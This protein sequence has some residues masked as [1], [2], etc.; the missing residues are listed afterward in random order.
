[1]SLS[2]VIE[3]ALSDVGY[4][5]SGTNLTKYGKAYG[6]DGKPWCVMALWYWFNRAGER[7]AFFGGG[8]TA[9]CGTLLRWYKEQGLTANDIQVGDIVILN[10]NGTTDTEHCGLV[11][12]VNGSSFY[13]VEGNTSSSGSQSNGDS[14]CRKWRIRSQVVGIC[15]PQYKE[16]SKVSDIDGHWSKEHFEWAIKNEIIT[17]YPNGAYKPDEPTKRSESV[18]MLHRLYESKIAVL[19]KRLDL[20]EEIVNKMYE[21][22]G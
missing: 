21:S 5:E 17:G 18:T 2:K 13:T 20:L 10:F 19:E 9:S 11:V 7:M 6:V 15:R 3:I 12:E 14:V 16:E 1:M 4:K 22:E 8:K